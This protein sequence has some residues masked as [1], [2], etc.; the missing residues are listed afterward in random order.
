MSILQTSTTAIDQLFGTVVTPGS[1][2]TF[3]QVAARATATYLFGLCLVRLGKSRLIAQTTPIDFILCVMIGAILGAGI[4]GTTTLFDSLIAAGALVALHWVCTW[5]SCRNHAFGNLINGYTK[6]LVEDGKINV[7]NLKSAHLSENDLR[8]GLRLNGNIDD[9]SQVKLA[10]K[11]RCGK[12]GVIKR[13]RVIDLDA[14][15]GIQTI[16]IVD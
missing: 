9:L 16:R 5:V 4:V 12:I 1:D 8:E 3:M 15:E 7:A 6:V 11:E 14:K 10:I 13:K 2:F